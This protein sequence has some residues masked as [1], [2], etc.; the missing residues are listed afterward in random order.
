MSVCRD[1]KRLYAKAFQGEILNFMGVDSV[2]EVP[3][4]PEVTV[5]T[6]SQ[7]PKQ[8]VSCV[9]NALT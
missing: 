9:L 4:N 5:F 8:S 3:E 7:S 1:V 2:Y 6:T